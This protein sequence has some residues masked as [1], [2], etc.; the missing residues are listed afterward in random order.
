V[1]GAATGYEVV[2]DG[3]GVGV[4]DGVS[5]AGWA[6]PVAVECSVGVGVGVCVAGW[7]S[8]AVSVPDVGV[9]VFDSSV[10]GCADVVAVEVGIFGAVDDPELVHA[11]T[12]AETRTVKVAQLTTVSLTLPAVP[13]A[14]LRTFIKPPL[15]PASN[16]VVSRSGIWHRAQ[17]RK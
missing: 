9:G 17:H 5:L 11:E 12:V 7:L 15:C 8:L 14:V 6:G 2:T 1:A 4:S 16:G 3:V 13:G 10:L